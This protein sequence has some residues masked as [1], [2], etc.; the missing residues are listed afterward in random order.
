MWIEYVKRDFY[1][2]LSLSL[3]VGSILTVIVYIWGRKKEK[4]VSTTKSSERAIYLFGKNLLLLDQSQVDTI[5]SPL[6]QASAIYYTCFDKLNLC[7]DDI[8]PLIKEDKQDNIVVFCYEYDK[9]ASSFLEH[10]TN[11]K[12]TILDHKTIYAMLE[13]INAL[14]TVPLTL[15]NEGKHTTVKQIL[16]SALTRSKA[17]SY[18]YSALL[19]SLG[20]MFLK[21]NIYYIVFSSF[22]YLLALYCVTNKRY[23]EKR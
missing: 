11:K 22:L 13:N 4:K 21:Y 12:V 16:S 14:P 1:L 7:I 17:K 18:F 3:L 5:L 15:W 6:K 19:L 23:N 9:E 2:S 20:S 10:V 8:L